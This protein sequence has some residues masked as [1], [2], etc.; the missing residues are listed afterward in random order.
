MH[1]GE[2]PHGAQG[3]GCVHVDCVVWAHVVFTV[4]GGHASAAEWKLCLFVCMIY[5]TRVCV[6]VCNLQRQT[7]KKNHLRMM[8]ESLV[9]FEK[10]RYIGHQFSYNLLFSFSVTL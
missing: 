7:R 4:L 9:A 10:N 6:C 1:C 8:Y 5:F 2:S 3:T